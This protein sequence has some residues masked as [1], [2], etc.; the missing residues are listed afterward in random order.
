[1]KVTGV[2]ANLP[3]SDVEAALSFYADYLDFSVE[4]M[5]LGW[6]ARFRTEGDGPRSS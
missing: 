3:V 2:T 1:M 6:V 5:N 4:G